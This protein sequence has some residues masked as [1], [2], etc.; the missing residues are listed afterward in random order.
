MRIGG[1]KS[2]AETREVKL[3]STTGL[4]VNYLQFQSKRRVRR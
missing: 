4:D 1:K 3:L 2:H